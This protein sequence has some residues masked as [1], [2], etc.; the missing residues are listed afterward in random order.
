MAK[1][2]RPRADRKTIDGS[3]LSKHP[4]YKAWA[5]MRDRCRNPKNTNYHK[6]GAR[7]VT[8][9][10]RWQYFENFLEDMGERPAGMTLD[11]IDNG[12]NY[13]PGNCRW[14]TPHVQAVNK[15]MPERNKTGYLGVS[16]NPRNRN[17]LAKLGTT[18]KFVHIGCY[19][20][21]EEAALAYDAAALQIHGPEATTN[22]L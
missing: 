8:V 9:C 16:W 21:P 3:Y 2:N 1:S 10:D 13:E 22:F 5:S 19:T 17:Y 11:R 4:L 12:G 18:G 14:A 7:G 15:R 20:D 6:Y